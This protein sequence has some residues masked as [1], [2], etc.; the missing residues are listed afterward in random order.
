MGM[1]I[2]LFFVMICKDV[3]FIIRSIF[4]LSVAYNYY[5][6]I[7]SNINIF[8]THHPSTFSSFDTDGIVTST[9]KVRLQVKILLGQI[10][11]G[12]S[13]GIVIVSSKTGK[14]ISKIAFSEKKK[15]NMKCLKYLVSFIDL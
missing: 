15:V 14:V 6:S 8:V 1:T 4:K 13:D 5:Q 3:F 7:L 12:A 9:D 2:D 10:W 11:I